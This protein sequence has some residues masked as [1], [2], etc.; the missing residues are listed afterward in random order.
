M[1]AIRDRNLLRNLTLWETPRH[2][3]G[4]FP[5]L[6]KNRI[7]R[8]MKPLCPGS[9]SLSIVADRSVENVRERDETRPL[10]SPA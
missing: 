7:S 8:S 6:A 1:N 4:L 9:E 2:Q 5:F 3:V 10:K